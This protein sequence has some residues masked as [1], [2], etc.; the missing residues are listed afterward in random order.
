MTTRLS[1]N[2]HNMDY[3]LQS[4]R[5]T[6]DI[7][8]EVADYQES[9]NG[10][11]K[12]V[13]KELTSHGTTPSGKPRLFVCNICTRA[14][15]RLEHLRRHER[16]HTKE[17]P[18]TCGMCQRKFSRRDLLLRHAQK[19]H[20]GQ[21]DA[22]VRLR[23]KLIKGE[24]PAPNS[25]YF[26]PDLHNTHEDTSMS[27]FHSPNAASSPGAAKDSLVLF[28]LN[29]FANR[30]PKGASQSPRITR[31]DSMKDSSLH[32]QVLDKN[33]LRNRSASFSAQSGPRY[34]MART[35][36]PELNTADN[37]EFSTPQL[38]PSSNNDE[39]SWL[40]NLCTIPGMA[41]LKSRH[42]MSDSAATSLI[43]AE[44]SK[45]P[46]LLGNGHPVPSMRSDSIASNT[47]VNTHDS[48]SA[49]PPFMIH[50]PSISG[51]IPN[52]TPAG[53]NSVDLNPDFGDY[54]Y[55]FYG[56][57]EN[58]YENQVSSLN[59]LR[60]LS[61]IKQEFDLEFMQLENPPA[62]EPFQMAATV[63]SG[64][65][66]D[67]NLLNDIDELGQDF[68]TGSKFRPAGYS[69]YGDNPLVSS[70]GIESSTPPALMSP[71]ILRANS[72]QFGGNQTQN[73][74]HESEASYGSGNARKKEYSRT[75]LY[76]KNMRQLINK[77]LSKYPISDVMP[78]S[79]PSNDKM[80]MFL[81]AF[82]TNFLSCYPFI[83]ASKLNEYE[84]M[85]MTSSESPDNESAR[86]CMPLLAATIG[87]L[88]VNSKDDSENLY[89]ASRRTIHIYLE[90][91]KNTNTSKGESTDNQNP[92]WLIQ[93][94]LL[95]VIYGLFSDNE[96]NVCI[97]IRQLNALNSLVKSSLKQNSE[98][99]FGIN[100]EDAENYKELQNDNKVSDAVKFKNH[101][102]LQSQVRTVLAIYQLTNFILMMF[103]VPLTFSAH[104][105]GSLIVP[106][107]NDEFLWRFYD[108]GELKEHL[109][110]GLYQ[111]YLDY[112]LKR[113]ANNTIYFQNTLS[114]LAKNEFDGDLVTHLS[115]LSKFGF[116]IMVKGLYETGQL[117]EYCGIDIDSILDN[118]T[119]FIDSAKNDPATSYIC[120]GSAD[121][122]KVDFAILVSFTKIC[123]VID[124]KQVKEQSWLKNY[125]VLNKNYHTLLM[126]MSKIHDDQFLKIIDNC[127]MICKLFLYRTEEVNLKY[128]MKAMQNPAHMD[129]TSDSNGIFQQLV[130]LSIHDEK[131]YCAAFEKKFGL[132]IY[133]DFFRTKTPIH[134][135][136]LFHIF[137]IFSIFSVHIARRN[138]SLSTGADPAYVRNFNSKFITMLRF[139]A[140]FEQHLKTQYSDSHLGPELTSLLLFLN[141]THDEILMDANHG[142]SNHENVFQNYFGY[143]LDKS[144]YVLK[145]GE[146]I[147]NFFYEQ[148]FKV[149][150]FKKLGSTLSQIRKFLIDEES[151]ILPN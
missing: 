64:V 94:L 90:S 145:M 78:P 133:E 6:N 151:K 14:F 18:F 5:L 99:F 44:I 3:L 130:D 135:Q 109:K 110:N 49:G 126:S 137:V 61:P 37:V 88:L 36:Y 124:F 119:L 69:F 47:S 101:I 50:K 139:L 114:S 138:R 38:L 31:A 105:L 131:E 65:D 35:Q 121:C 148:N 12:R 52:S 17:K 76:T 45:N 1:T 15:A 128:S 9:L 42:L 92:L 79:I 85:S 34:A 80:E 102:N 43:D 115:N 98:I 147:M 67:L 84:I 56:I 57:P 118:M 11:K 7:S 107:T 83:H 29:S 146:L 143:T 125:E 122:E 70:S 16:S 106:N 127:I 23:M 59:T 93:S 40:N 68:E 28:N 60:P 77:A 21:A 20:S 54:G 123:A 89:E 24:S 22:V 112:Y 8:L 103:N 46:S 13:P 25:D 136:V 81:K 72:Y 150:I 111:N 96:N 134:S 63:T 66:F 4:D 140:K 41:L 86:V 48:F 120:H 33:N 117:R 73:Q 75:C 30:N 91:R 113:N 2:H 116:K 142:I 71:S 55:S 149:S 10:S 53:S 19:L 108:I 82:N 87:A 97:V 27:S 100:G 95:S 132:K 26:D 39:E 104:D 129:T 32:K 62:V 58:P 74:S 141:G 144:L 51:P